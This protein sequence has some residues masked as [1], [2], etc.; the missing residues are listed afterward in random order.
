[1]VGG[2]G[3]RWGRVEGTP[4]VRTRIYVQA[5]VGKKGQAGND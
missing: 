5:T 2:K 1:M 3:K 4:E